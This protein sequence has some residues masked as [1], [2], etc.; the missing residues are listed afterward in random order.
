MK[1][2][3]RETESVFSRKGGTGIVP[4]KERRGDVIAIAETESAETRVAICQKLFMS[5]KNNDD[6]LGEAVRAMHCSILI[7]IFENF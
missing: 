1:E 5:T 6:D 4:F 7:G 3:M 2:L